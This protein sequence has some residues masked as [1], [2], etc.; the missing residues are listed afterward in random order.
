MISRLLIVGLG[1]GLISRL[2]KPMLDHY[3]LL[4]QLNFYYLVQMDS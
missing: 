2:S 4:D 1:S 3:E